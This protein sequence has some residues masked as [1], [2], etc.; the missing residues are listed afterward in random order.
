MNGDVCIRASGLP[1]L[2]RHFAH[3]TRGEFNRIVI[4]KARL[5]PEIAGVHDSRGGIHERLYPL[6][7]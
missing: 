7:G 6:F 1:V 5:I 2:V 3:A 4:K